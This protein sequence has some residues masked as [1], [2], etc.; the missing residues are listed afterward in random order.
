MYVKFGHSVLSHFDI[1]DID[2]IVEQ[3]CTRFFLPF[4]YFYFVYTFCTIFHNK[5]SL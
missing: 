3:L 4:Y 5:Y 2:I 1:A